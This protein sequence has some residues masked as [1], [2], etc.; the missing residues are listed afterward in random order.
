MLKFLTAELLADTREFEPVART[1]VVADPVPTRVAGRPESHTD[2]G[3][4]LLSVVGGVR[5]PALR[6]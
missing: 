2:S 5:R 1:A 4:R 6:G 3:P